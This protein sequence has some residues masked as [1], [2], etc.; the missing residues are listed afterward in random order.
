MLEHLA[1]RARGR[2][3]RRFVAD[4]LAENARMWQV[5]TDSGLPVRRHIADAVT[6]VD[7][8][9]APAEGYL[10]ALAEREER[11]DVASLSAVLSPRSIVV[12][13]AGRSPDSVGHAVLESLVQA[14]FT[15]QLAAVN[16]HAEEVCGVV[17]RRSVEELTGSRWTSRSCACPP[18]RCRRWPS[19][20]GAPGCGRCW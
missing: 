9:L 3:V 15:G 20:V 6:H 17:C 14:G 2:G 4:V 5:I 1:S 13:G 19:S 11:A 18:P 8:D 10:D 16:P 7:L 12:V